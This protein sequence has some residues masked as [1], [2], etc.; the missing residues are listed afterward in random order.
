M[1]IFPV[2]AR[3]KLHCHMKHE[4]TSQ[5]FRICIAKYFDDGE[6]SSDN[7]SVKNQLAYK[8]LP[9]SKATEESMASNSM[10]QRLKDICL[11]MNSSSLSILRELVR[12]LETMEKSS[13]INISIEK[14]KTLVQE[15]KDYLKSLPGL[16]LTLT[17]SE[18]KSP[19][20]DKTEPFLTTNNVVPLTEVI[21]LVA[22]ASL[23]I[24]ISVCIETLLRQFK[25]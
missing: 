1:L 24:E 17:Y 13:T 10:K 9:N 19:V 5:I 15:L 22:F 7:A 25:S 12:N 21:P 20:T 8:G 18:A 4:K 14:M 16:V 6:K 11:K 3:R 23:L 2:R